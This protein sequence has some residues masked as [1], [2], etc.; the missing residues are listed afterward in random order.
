MSQATYRGAHYDTDTRKS[1]MVINWLPLIKQQI[2]KENRIYQAQV[3]M[4]KK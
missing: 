4:A 2:E 1:E 3:E